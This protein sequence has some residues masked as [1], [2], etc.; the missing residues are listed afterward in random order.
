[1]LVDDDPDGCRFSDELADRVRARG[2][3]ARHVIA[4]RWRPAA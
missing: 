4:N 1:V 2:I 3:E